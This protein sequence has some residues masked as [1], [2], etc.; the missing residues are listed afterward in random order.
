M[1]SR[2]YSEPGVHD[3]FGDLVGD[4]P[5]GGADPVGED[6]VGDEPEFGDGA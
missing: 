1:T 4:R 6:P 2:G 3:R 5:A